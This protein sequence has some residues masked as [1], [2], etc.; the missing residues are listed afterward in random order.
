LIEPDLLLF[1][2]NLEREIAL[3]FIKVDLVPLVLSLLVAARHGGLV[4]RGD[5]FFEFPRKDLVSGLEIVAFDLRSKGGE[6]PP[7]AVRDLCDRPS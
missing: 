4:R 2:P 5:R 1:V 7:A 3:H 6:D